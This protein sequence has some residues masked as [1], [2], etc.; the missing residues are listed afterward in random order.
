MNCEYR[1]MI[2]NYISYF[3]KYKTQP[4]QIYELK[5]ITEKLF[6]RINIKRKTPWF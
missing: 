2:L 4:F 6:F 3:I 5:R 1:S